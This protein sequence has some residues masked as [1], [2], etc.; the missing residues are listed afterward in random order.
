MVWHFLLDCYGG[1]VFL[2]GDFCWVV[3]LLGR[4]FCGGVFSLWDY[5]G[6]VVFLLVYWFLNGLTSFLC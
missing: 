1:V 4:L 3:F 2:F 5:Y 6:V